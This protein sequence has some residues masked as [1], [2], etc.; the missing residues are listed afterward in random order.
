MALRSSEPPGSRVCPGPCSPGAQSTGLDQATP[1][2]PAG[3]GREDAAPLPAHA[4]RFQSMSTQR[5]EQGPAAPQPRQACVR[6]ARGSP[7]LHRPR[8]PVVSAPP[9]APRTFLLPSVPQGRQR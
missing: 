6:T 1:T 7:L 3:S 5:W 4:R 9:G 2:S 8:T